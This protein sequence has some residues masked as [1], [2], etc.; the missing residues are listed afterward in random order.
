M[1]GRFVN[2]SNDTGRP[3][4]AAPLTHDPPPADAKAKALSCLA[5]GM[6]ITGNIVCDGPMR[7]FGRIE[8]EVRG[9]VIEIGEG[10]E[11]EGN[12][13]AD[14]LIIRGRV[15]GTIRA[16]RVK[17]LGNGAVEGDIFHRSLS[18]EEPARF[19]GG[20]RPVENPTEQTETRTAPAEMRSAGPQR[21]S[22]FKPSLAP[23]GD[24]APDTSAA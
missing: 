5:A 11:V 10:A 23:I 22:I 18:I 20:S 16:T 8:G 3:A 19:E 14:E 21:R 12:I 17:L 24:I 1:L 13:T 15:K 9:G 7:V 6:S 4:P 2:R